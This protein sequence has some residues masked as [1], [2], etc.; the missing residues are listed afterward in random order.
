MAQRVKSP[1]SIHE[2]AGSIPGLTEQVKDLALLQ[3]YSEGQRCRSDL[4]FL[5]LWCRPAAA[6]PIRPLAWE[7]RYAAGAA[8]KTTTTKNKNKKTPQKTPKPTSIH[9][10]TGS[11]LGPAQWDKDPALP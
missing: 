6:A 2:D 5:W 3:A 9:E 8:L 10:D 7:L 4:A 11:I 1:T